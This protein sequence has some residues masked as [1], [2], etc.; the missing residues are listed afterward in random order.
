MSYQILL[1]RNHRNSYT[2][3][4]V[5]FPSLAAKGASRQEAL[6]NIRRELRNHLSDM[7]IVQIDSLEPRSAAEHPGVGMFVDDPTWEEFLEEVE[8]HRAKYNTIPEEVL[9]DETV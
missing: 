5:G 1:H 2:A 6:E 8:A 3:T 9:E 7:E 4:A